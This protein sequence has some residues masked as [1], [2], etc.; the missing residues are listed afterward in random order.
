VN[1]LEAKLGE[2][3]SI[4]EAMKN[5]ASLQTNLS[6]LVD[7]LQTKPSD[8]YEVVASV[9][10]LGKKLDILCQVVKD[11]GNSGWQDSDEETKYVSLSILNKPY[12]RMLL[13]V[14]AFVLF[15]ASLGVI[16]IAGHLIVNLI[17]L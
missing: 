5:F 12:M 16:F 15:L 4:A 14:L 9:D 3:N 8:S 6:N 10:K 11:S 7:A 1:L 17:K 13:Y 2:L